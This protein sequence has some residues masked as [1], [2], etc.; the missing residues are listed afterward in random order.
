MLQS[1]GLLY[2]MM[3]IA[4]VA[5]IV[6]SLIGIATIAGWMPSALL[7]SSAVGESPSV[8]QVDDRRAHTPAFGCAECSV[9][10]SIRAMEARAERAAFTNET[11]AYAPPRPPLVD[12]I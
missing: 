5:V 7:G 12:G 2:P 9:I 8:A 11:V 1:R 10:E 4:A 3:V 6:F